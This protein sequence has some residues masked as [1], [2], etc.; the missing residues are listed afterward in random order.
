V[1]QVRWIEGA[2]EH[3]ETLR[4]AQILGVVSSSLAENTEDALRQT[5]QS[6]RLVGP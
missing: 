2:A 6:C 1:P 4:H 3:P 5:A